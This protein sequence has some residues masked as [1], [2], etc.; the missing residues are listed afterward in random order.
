MSDVFVLV[1]TVICLGGDLS[2]LAKSLR[3]AI[4]KP[5]PTPIESKVIDVNIVMVARF[6]SQEE[7]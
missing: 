2:I 1:L 7:C 6:S 5:M 4:A 3:R